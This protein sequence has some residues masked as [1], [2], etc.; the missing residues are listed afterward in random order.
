MH[1]IIKHGNW[2]YQKYLLDKT[3]LNLRYPTFQLALNLISEIENPVIVETGCQR[4]EN[5]LGAGM[6]TSIFGEYVT[7]YGGL[8]N[9]VDNNKEHLSRARKFIEKQRISGVIFY[10]S[11][12]VKWLSEWSG[13][14]NLLYLD[15]WDYPYVEMMQ[16][17]SRERNISMEE[18]HVTISQ[19]HRNQ[20]VER[21]GSTII[22][23]QEHTV[24]EYEAIKNKLEK[25]SILLIDDNSLPG[26]GKPG[27][28]KPILESDGW[29]C[30][31]D[32]QQCLWIK[33]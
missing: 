11:D 28:V 25:G 29:S 2:F 8:F 4:E 13:G 32:M 3:G 20:L 18:A 12:S 14:I 24:R 26:G 9:V 33:K 6:S 27:L 30:I 16:E 19:W 23:C 5:D 10:H 21:W 17:V 31:F 1:E 7:R 15:S 22:P